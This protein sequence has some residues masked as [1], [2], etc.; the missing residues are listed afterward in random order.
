MGCWCG[1]GGYNATYA[2]TCFLS[3]TEVCLQLGMGKYC[4]TKNRE[5]SRWG[6]II[7]PRGNKNVTEYEASSFPFDKTTEHSRWSIGFKGLS[8]PDL[9]L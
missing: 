9:P 3:P 4:N 5:W 1:T 6:C 8:L 2:R 7:S